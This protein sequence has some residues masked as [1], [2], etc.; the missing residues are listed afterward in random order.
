MFDLE[1]DDVGYFE[2]SGNIYP[3]TLRDIL[4]YLSVNLYLTTF[5]AFGN[6]RSHRGCLGVLRCD[7]FPESA[8]KHVHRKEI[9]CIAIFQIL[10][11]LLR[12]VLLPLF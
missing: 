5:R 6:E 1:E 9:S 12:E 10:G 2:M 3:T 7:C 8:S 4:E 11:S